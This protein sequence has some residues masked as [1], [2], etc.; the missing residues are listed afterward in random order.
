M[1]R[2]YTRGMT[3]SRALYRNSRSVYTAGVKSARAVSEKCARQ[4]ANRKRN[5]NL[6][7]CRPSVAAVTWLY[8]EAKRQG[9]PI[10]NLAARIIEQ[11]AA[12]GAAA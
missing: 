9:V 6:V 3:E 5:V 12:R 11:A 2:V 10:S 4:M 1:G 7:S 8:A